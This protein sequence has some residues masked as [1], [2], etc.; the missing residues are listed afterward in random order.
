MGLYVFF[1]MV[2][3]VYD[4]LL[5]ENYKLLFEVEGLLIVGEEEE[6]IVGGGKRQG[7][8]MIVKLFLKVVELSGEDLG[9]SRIN[10]W[11]YI[12]FSLFMGSFIMFVFEVD[13]DD[14]FGGYGEFLR[15]LSVMSIFLGVSEMG[16]VVE[17]G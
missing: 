11:R 4:F 7:G 16:I 5:V 13:E 12:K 14:S 15:R 1:K 10:I 17:V 6:K 3:D 2:C 9:L 8:I